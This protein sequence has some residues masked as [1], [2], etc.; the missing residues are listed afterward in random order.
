MRTYEMRAEPIGSAVFNEVAPFLIA[1][2]AIIFLRILRR[3]R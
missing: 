2:G 1:I 3:K